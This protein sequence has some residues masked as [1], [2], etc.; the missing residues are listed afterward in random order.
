LKIAAI[1]G[2]IEQ[3]NSILEKNTDQNLLLNTDSQG[4]TILHNCSTVEPA[5]YILSVCPAEKKKCL[6]ETKSYS[7]ETV[8]HCAVQTGCPE[9]TSLFL[10]E[11]NPN[12]KKL[13]FE[14]DGHDSTALHFARNVEVA[15]VL[16]NA[17]T[18]E[19]QIEF[20][21]LADEFGL[22]ALHQASTHRCVDV[23]SLFLD[24]VKGESQKLLLQSDVYGRTPLAYAGN[25]ATVELLV[26]RFNSDPTE[27]IYHADLEGR[28]PF[29]VTIDEGYRL[30]VIKYFIEMFDSEKQKLIRMAA[31]DG[32]TT[33]HGAE[34]VETARILVE[35]V[36]PEDR[37]PFIFQENTEGQTA[38][39][40][41]AEFDKEEVLIYLADQ[42]KTDCIKLLTARDKQGR[43]ALHLANEKAT[44]RRLLKLF[45]AALELSID[46]S[47]G[48]VNGCSYIK[49][50][51]NCGD[52]AVSIALVKNDVQYDM[53]K[54]LLKHAFEHGT[55]QDLK[56][57]LE[58]RN[59]SGRNV[60]HLACL[61]FSIEKLF[62]VLESYK[63]FVD[64][65]A[66]VLPDNYGNS[67]VSYIA[68]KYYTHW[69][70]DI[71]MQLPLP[72]RRIL[73]TSKNTK[74]VNVKEIVHRQQF[75][76][77]Y[78]LESILGEP[79]MFVKG[80]EGSSQVQKTDSYYRTSFQNFVYRPKRREDDVILKVIN[81][82]LNYYS[83]I[84]PGSV[85]S[86]ALCVDSLDQSSHHQFKRGTISKARIYN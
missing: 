13:L 1:N 33:L 72:L 5:K 62:R 81:Y 22:T 6:L 74:G 20:I 77:K 68:A 41:A 37:I 70:A 4:R 84:D 82:A 31:K 12:S 36:A 28:T 23:I 2:E 17:L 56:F 71:L 78:F 86:L 19:D 14:K 67:P 53:F 45:T 27:Y 10:N 54:Y 80:S 85:T 57:L 44:A 42:V 69:F 9:L 49:Q 64:V 61:S 16:L 63:N 39:H 47:G 26:R 25:S 30:D 24:T 7:G 48:L 76:R 83:I 55:K 8:L 40:S 34:D 60:F 50:L 46:S 75:D 15:Q 3:M 11:I 58:H 51:D 35:A 38:F 32:S 18:F 43:N 21:F 66:V 73:C 52:S 29:R 59:T 79:Y 65:Q